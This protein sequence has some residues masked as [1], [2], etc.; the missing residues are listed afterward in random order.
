[1]PVVTLAALC[2]ACT[3][4]PSLGMPAHFES[5]SEEGNCIHA[6]LL[7]EHG[8]VTHAGGC[9]EHDDGAPAPRPLTAHQRARLVAALDRLRASSL[10]DRADAGSQACPFGR[11]FNL[12]ER[13]GASRTWD[14]CGGGPAGQGPPAQVP[15]ELIHV[16]EAIVEE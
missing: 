11:R 15:E 12:V 10:Y 7:D 1:M 6:M 16:L 9:E 8:V 5:T 3:P 4:R 14:F 13:A 2:A